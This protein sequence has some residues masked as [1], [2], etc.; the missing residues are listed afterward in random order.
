MIQL[1]GLWEP[2]RPYAEG[3]L[4]FAQRQGVTPAVTSVF[5]SWEKQ[6]TLRQRWEACVASGEAYRSKRCR[7]PANP[8]G[9]SA[10]NYGWAWDSWVP[11][12][13]MS[14]WAA[15]RRA[16]GWHVPENDLIHA[17]LPGWK[18]FVRWK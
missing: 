15:V 16:Y 14:W 11:A 6:A 2:L 1:A 10:H 13:Y 3:A 18:G 9:Y 7:Y 17:E 12:E 4:S 8:P 5:R